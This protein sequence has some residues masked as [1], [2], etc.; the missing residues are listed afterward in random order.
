MVDTGEL[1]ELIERNTREDGTH[2]TA[3]PRVFLHRASKVSMQLHTV[4]EPALC[5]MAQG[6]KHALAG[7]KVHI[8]GQ[9]NYLIVSVDIPIVAQI[10]EASPEHP[11]LCLRI[12]LD[13][14]T[15]GALMLESDFE[16]ASREQPVAALAVSDLDA[17]VLDASVRLLRLLDSPRD[18]PI[19]APLAEREILYRLLRGEQTSRM[20]Q[21]AFGE[22]KLQQVNRAIAWI[23]RNFRE[24]FSVE[25][26][27]EEARMSG[28]ALHQHFKA[29]TGMSPLQYQ[30]QLRLQEA[31]RLMLTEATDAAMAGHSVGYDS[32]SQ[33]SREYRRLFGAPPLRDIEKLR[34]SIGELST[35]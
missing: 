5:I 4:Y 7:E 26:L 33:F 2:A 20:S 15:I 18:V 28:S 27:A 11:F 31:R 34:A 12:D 30:K 24:A 29:V 32:P 17:G 22:S 9:G 35:A 6:Q 3:I 13:P 16:R 1:A 8:Y 25:A 19:L 10:T 23:K 14:A 21:I